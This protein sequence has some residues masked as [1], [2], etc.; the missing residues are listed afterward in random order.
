MV[1]HTLS[2][3]FYPLL[4]VTS[5]DSKGICQELINPLSPIK[6]DQALCIENAKKNTPFE[7]EL[8]CGKKVRC[9]FLQLADTTYRLRYDLSLFSTLHKTLDD[10]MQCT[11]ISKTHTAND[12]WKSQIDASISAYL[13]KHKVAI[14]ALCASKK[15]EIIS[16]LSSQGLF[17]FKEASVFIASRLKMSRASV[18]NYLKEVENFKTVKIHQVDTCTDKKFAGNPAGVVLDAQHLDVATMRKITRELNLSETA[19]VLPSKTDDFELRYFTPTGHEIAFCGHSTIGS[20]FMLAKEKRY[21]MTGPGSYHFNVKT[22]CGTL[23]MQVLLKKNDIQL[24]Y[25]TPVIDFQPTT[26][27][28]HEVAK[29]IEIPLNAINKNVPVM[30]EKTNKDLYITLTSLKALHKVQCNAKALSKFCKEHDLVAVCLVTPFTVDPKNDLHVRCFAPSVGIV[31]DPFTGSVLGGLSAYADTFGL[32]P[33]GQFRVEQGH[34]L[35]RPGVAHV[36]YEKK[37][38]IF[39][40]SVTA[41]SVHCFSTEIHLT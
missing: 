27:S 16:Q 39:T 25:Q 29:A 9:A 4:E 30:I 35:N 20:L 13:H 23:S 41:S 19:F 5:F 31:E 36:R 18:Y 6:E 34:I 28:H 11:A 3:L 15:R 24:C 26:I 33:K 2:E 7:E 22:K 17:D 10:I 12:H 21:A 14:D 32:T 1:A 37:K 8:R 38:N 40:A